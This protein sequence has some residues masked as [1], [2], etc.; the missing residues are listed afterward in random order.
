MKKC[1]FSL[2]V[3]IICCLAGCGYSA[4]KKY[5][6]ETDDY[7]EIWNLT[8]FHHGYE[9]KS[10]LFPEKI[11]GL[12]VSEFHCRYDEQLPLGEGVQIFLKVNYDSDSFET[13][14]KRISDVATENTTEFTN[15]EFSAYAVRLGDDG[16]YEYALTNKTEKTVCYIFIYGLPE[17]EIEI[18]KAFLPNNYIDYG[19]A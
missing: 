13:E 3:I 7:N 9:D 12:G 18:E 4:Y 1:V 15:D 8:G 5:Y 17:K 6:N 14:L 11:D 2:L 19:D 10:P 16:C